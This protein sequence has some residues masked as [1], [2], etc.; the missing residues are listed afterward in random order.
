MPHKSNPIAAISARASARRAPHLAAHLFAQMEQEHERA[1]GA[2]HAEWSA[3]VDLLR[4]TGSACWWLA[5][6]LD[7][8]EIDLDAVER[9]R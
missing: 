2:W 3:L 6:S 9:N 8:L 4:A 5:E 1:A 7:S